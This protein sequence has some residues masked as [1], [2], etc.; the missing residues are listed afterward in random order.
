VDTIRRE[1]VDG[2][3]AGPAR[4]V[5]LAI[6]G[7]DDIVL[8]AQAAISAAGAPGARVLVVHLPQVWPSRFAEDPGVQIAENLAQ[9][10]KLIEEA[11]ISATG[12]VARP[13]QGANVIA[14]IAAK[15]Q[16]DVTVM[17]SSRRGDLVTMVLGSPS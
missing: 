11:G 2:T 15:W 3:A 7:G 12:V 10:I 16:A 17:G 4:Q 6:S 8:A 14:R 9:T 1:A 13:D 5:L